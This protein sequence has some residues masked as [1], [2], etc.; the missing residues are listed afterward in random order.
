M[1]RLIAFLQRTRLAGVRPTPIR[2]DGGN[3]EAVTG[4][5]GGSGAGAA[6][7]HESARS[8][9]TRLFLPAGS[10]ICKEPLGPDADRRLRHEMAF[11]SR[12]SGVAGV[13]QLAD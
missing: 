5:Q 11:L 13:A 4:D 6:L 3:G 2:P 1:S 7:L 8:R 10:V 9:V 12:L